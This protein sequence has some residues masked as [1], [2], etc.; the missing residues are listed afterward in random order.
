MIIRRLRDCCS[1]ILNTELLRIVLLQYPYETMILI[2]REAQSKRRV[3][4][5]RS[6]L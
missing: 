6:F 2:A 4:S 5:A 1:K 3:S